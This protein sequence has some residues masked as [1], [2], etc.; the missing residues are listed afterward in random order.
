MAKKVRRSRRSVRVPSGVHD[1]TFRGYVPR[2]G[3]DRPQHVVG[4]LIDWS[5]ARRTFLF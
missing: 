1:A 5:H 3:M 4:N 2:L